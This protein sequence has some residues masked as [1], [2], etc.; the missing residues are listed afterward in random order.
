MF[1]RL[2]KKQKMRGIPTKGN[3]VF[4]KLELIG[5][6]STL[7]LFDH[8]KEEIQIRYDNKQNIFVLIYIFI[9]RCFVKLM[10]VIKN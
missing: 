7:G 2:I 6:S 8:L 3:E 9:G 10:N 5:Y 1:Y 4:G